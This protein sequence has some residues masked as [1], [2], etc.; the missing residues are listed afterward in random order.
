VFPLTSYRFVLFT[1]YV[2][3]FYHDGDGNRSQAD[4]II[5]SV[6]WSS[7]RSLFRANKS[8]GQQYMATML[9]HLKCCH[10]R[11]KYITNMYHNCFR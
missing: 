3:A 9:S 6:A 5:M 7:N 4:I 8:F 11:R 2:P 1:E 10:S